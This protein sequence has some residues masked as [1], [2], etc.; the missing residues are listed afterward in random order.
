[1]EI[2]DSMWAEA[3][4]QA[5]SCSSLYDSMRLH[6]KLFY[7]ITE[8]VTLFHTVLLYGFLCLSD[9]FKKLTFSSKSSQYP[10]TS[11]EPWHN[12]LHTYTLCRNKLPWDVIRNVIAAWSDTWEDYMEL[13]GIMKVVERMWNQLIISFTGVHLRKQSAFSSIHAKHRCCCQP[14]QFYSLTSGCNASPN[15]PAYTFFMLFNLKLLA[16]PIHTN[17]LS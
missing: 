2:L 4:G 1:M 15:T 10:S 17:F 5:V 12:F 9:C 13:R 3:A 8:H 16:W 7:N 6:V 14:L 11:L